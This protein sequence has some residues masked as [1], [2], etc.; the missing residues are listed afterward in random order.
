MEAANHGHAIIVTALLAVPGIDVNAK[1]S[2]RP[3]H[4]CTALMCAAKTGHTAI[5]T[6]LLAVPGIDVNAKDNVRSS[7]LPRLPPTLSH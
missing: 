2:V 4:G 1:D 6:A 7:L 5:V 3:A